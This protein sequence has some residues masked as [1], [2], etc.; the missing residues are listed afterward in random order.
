MCALSPETIDIGTEMVLESHQL[1]KA[2][3]IGSLIQIE[4]DLIDHNHK[5]LTRGRLYEVLAKTDQSPCHQ[6]FVVQSELTRELVELHPGLIC[7]YL[8]SPA[9]VYRA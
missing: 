3:P 9:E 4:A 6:M 7:N 5:V 1:W 8:D 2:I